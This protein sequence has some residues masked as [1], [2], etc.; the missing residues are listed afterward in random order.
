MMMVIASV[1]S[2]SVLRSMVVATTMEYV[3]LQP[4]PIPILTS[5]ISIDI[6]ID[7][8]LINDLRE[9]RGVVHESDRC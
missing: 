4:I 3:V 1:P 8:D 7:V 6:D 9:L 2:L 5:L